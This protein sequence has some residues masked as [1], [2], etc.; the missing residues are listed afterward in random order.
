[1]SVNWSLNLSSGVISNSTYTQPLTPPQLST[2]LWRKQIH[3]Y[4][5]DT[6]HWQFEITPEDKF[7]DQLTLIQLTQKNIK[8]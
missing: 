2:S 3:K 6:A 4:C 5:V 1:M 8:Q 7:K